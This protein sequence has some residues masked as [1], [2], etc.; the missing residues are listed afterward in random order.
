[1]HSLQRQLR[2]RLLLGSLAVGVLL[3]GTATWL[4]QRQVRD[5]L[6]YQLEQVAR[7]LVDHDFN[8]LA[9]PPLDDPAM[10]L[11]VQV[12]DREGKLLYRSS[13]ESNVGAATPE[14]LSVVS[15]GAPPEAIELRL[16]TLRG[17]QRTVQVMQ[18]IALRSELTTEAGL[19]ILAATLL[20]TAALSL[21]VIATVR[22]ALRPL[23]R[24]AGELN[25]RSADSLDPILLP[26]APSE[27]QST[28]GTLNE[29][30]ARLRGSVLAHRHFVA[31]AA[32][33]L[34]TPLAALRLQI[35]NAVRAS[36][37]AQRAEAMRQLSQGSERIQRLI[38]QL[39]TLARLESGSATA[40][41]F[42]LRE[43]AKEC[44]IE[45]APLA[46]ASGVE[47]SFN[48]PRPTPVLAES[49]AIRILIGNLIGNALVHAAAG[50]N[51]E[52]NIVHET[53]NAVLVVRDRG[54]GIPAALRERV[55]ERFFRADP[56]P[57]PGSGLGLAIVAEIARIHGAV[58]ELRT[59]ADGFG[60]EV[61]V[62]MPAAAA[63]VEP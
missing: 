36:G 7:T 60:L 25:R 18:P 4:T 58:V 51:V 53:N 5:L 39:L 56:G 22:R 34:R 6:D 46:S 31:D 35:D 48:A 13:E 42:D 30:L 23:L 62:S 41:R 44:L 40:A 15:D 20:G 50:R 17:E 21:L 24:L 3:A 33:E 2:W 19:E 26:D 12:W 61:A 29:L 55:F 27:L 49:G 47:L 10:H 45:S 59:P 11:G 16:F 38:E 63:S 57:R 9:Q 14:G 28:L 43:L 32:H 1:M 52:I 54:P 8:R 37:D